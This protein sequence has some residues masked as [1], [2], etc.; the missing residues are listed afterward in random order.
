MARLGDRRHRDEPPVVTP[1]PL[2][3]GCALRATC[4]HEYMQHSTHHAKRPACVGLREAHRHNLCYGVLER[5]TLHHPRI[6][7][8]R[9]PIL[10]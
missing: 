3:C 1:R 9:A 4:Q 10:L 7:L 8:P 2:A 6:R 5:S